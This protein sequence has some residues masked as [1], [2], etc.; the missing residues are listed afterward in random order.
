MFSLARS[1]ARIAPTP[2]CHTK[3]LPAR[4]TRRSLAARGLGDLVRSV[5]M[6]SGG[7][8][9]GEGWTPST[10]TPAHPTLLLPSLPSIPTFTPYPTT[11]L[12]ILSY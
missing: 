10:G 2:S 12:C 8:T 7:S 1:T 9:H 4:P 6:G 11:H 5:I 3:T